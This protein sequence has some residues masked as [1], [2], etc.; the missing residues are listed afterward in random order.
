MNELV[1]VVVLERYRAK[2]MPGITDERFMYAVLLDQ[3]VPRKEAFEHA[4]GMEGTKARINNEAVCTDVQRQRE[5]FYA[6]PDT[7]P[8]EVMCEDELR[9]RLTT[10]VRGG[11]GAKAKDMIAAARLLSGLMGWGK[12]S[13]D[14]GDDEPMYLKEVVGCVK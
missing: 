5:L 1:D 14:D 6:N 10:I 12:A 7:I 9:A 13:R 11:L 2:K 3:D 8:R 4:Y